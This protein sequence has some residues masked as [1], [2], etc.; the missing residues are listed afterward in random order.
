MKRY[1]E[2]HIHTTFTTGNSTLTITDA[3]ARAQKYGMD[4][5]GIM[6]S[7]SM[8]GVDQFISRCSEANIKPI[9]GC[10]F[11]LT[12]GD[13]RQSSPEKYHLP[14]IA[15]TKK[16]YDNLV[17]LDS[18]AHN[19]GFLTRPQ[20]DLRLLSKY[21]SGLIVLTG[22]RGGAVDKLLK[23]NERSSAMELLTRLEAITDRNSLF[24]ELQD[25]GRPVDSTANK[26]LALL[27]GE[28]NLPMI[29]T[30]GPF[31]LDRN[32]AEECNLLRKES[33]NGTLT[34]DQFNFRSAEEQ[35]NIFS[36]Y[37]DALFQSGKVADRC[38]DISL[39]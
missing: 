37:E 38:F 14:I 18:I 11:Y 23:A 30:G 8:A 25:N 15:L 7:G 34:G 31:Y 12:L 3:V 9:I 1:I 32:N 24:V 36:S 17:K 21:S 33:G 2:L 39:C 6:D 35:A 4:C 27:A 19:E 16:G 10:G 26:M 20:I 29:V 5:L 28:C 22:G 13:H